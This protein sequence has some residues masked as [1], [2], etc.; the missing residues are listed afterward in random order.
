MGSVFY[1]STGYFL[2]IFYLSAIYRLS[3]YNVL[4]W[5]PTFYLQSMFHLQNV[6][7]YFL[8]LYASICQTTHIAA[9]FTNS[10][11]HS[12]R[13][14]CCILSI[15]IWTYSSLHT[16]CTTNYTVL[17][18]QTHFPTSIAADHTEELQSYMLKAYNSVD[19]HSSTPSSGAIC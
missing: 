3:I 13:R 12:L 5:P 15:P 7:I 16:H 4:C 10:I 9:F 18:Q 19:L 14:Y 6:L 17:Q 2:L 8:H 11:L 1:L